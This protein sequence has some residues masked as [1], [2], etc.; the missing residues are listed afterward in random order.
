MPRRFSGSAAVPDCPQLPA[1]GYLLL[2][3]EKGRDPGFASVEFAAR[4]AALPGHLGVLAASETLGMHGPTVPGG[5]SSN[6]TPRVR[7]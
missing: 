7:Q 5:D 4:S 2:G 6:G 3:T 1:F